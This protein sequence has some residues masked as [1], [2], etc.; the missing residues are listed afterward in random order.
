MLG[1]LEASICRNRLGREQFE[2]SYLCK[3]LDVAGVAIQKE[4]AGAT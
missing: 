3:Q 4:R 1:R 2:T